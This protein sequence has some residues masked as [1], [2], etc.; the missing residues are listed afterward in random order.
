MPGLPHDFRL[1]LQQ[2][3]LPEYRLPFLQ[4]LASGCPGGL[5]VFFGQPLPQEN[6]GR[7]EARASIPGVQWSQVR[8]RH[9][10]TPQSPFFVCWQDGLL[11]WLES[12]QPGALVVEAN[13]RYLSTRR[14]VSWMHRTK[15]PVLGWGLGA[16]PLTGV[17]GI[18]RRWERRLFL[19][20]LDG[21][22]AYSQRGADQYRSLGLPAERIFVAHN[23]AVPRPSSPAP[24]RPDQ[25]HGRPAVLFVGRL[26]ERK[27]ID[28]L[29]KACS[30]LAPETQPDL[31][32][33][34][35]GPARP[36]LE[37][38]ARQVYPRA[39]F[40]GEVRGPALDPYLEAADLF[41]L[42]GTGG[43]ALQQAMASGLPAIV[44]QGDGTQDDLVRPGSGWQI[45]AE[46]TGD[47][48]LLDALVQALGSALQDPARLRRMG[49]E[50]Y[51]I[52][53]EEIN[54]NRMAEAFVEAVEKVV[55]LGVR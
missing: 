25:F 18:V 36:G 17:L 2:R 12:W 16:P 28:L 42:P 55:R 41:V 1:G 43:L 27:R 22:I 53:A 9:F 32:V 13:P 39:V 7:M 44:A 37:A 48:G 29:L 54:L 45:E 35:D 51:R 23:A 50:A 3:V 10:L 30:A 15:R 26:Q 4:V 34:G 33:V 38:L 8:N 21:W 40:T 14:A 11:G 31:T 52:V 5:S 19:R 49:R 20:S 6:L 47:E 46:G 24:E